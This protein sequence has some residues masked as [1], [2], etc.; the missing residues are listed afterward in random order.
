MSVVF[1][2]DVMSIL[3]S[4]YAPGTNCSHLL[5]G[6][7]GQIVRLHFEKMKISKKTPV[8]QDDPSDCGERL[9]LYDSDWADPQRIVK[10]FCSHF[11]EAKESTDFVTRGRSLYIS[12]VSPSGSYS[13]S[14]IYYWAIYDFHDASLDGERVR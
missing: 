4:R 5:R 2:M 1:I 9:I 8:I 7:P 13:G 12:F 3:L 6:E 10:A 11:S 14:S